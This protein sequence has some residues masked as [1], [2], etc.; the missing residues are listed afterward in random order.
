MSGHRHDSMAGTQNQGNTLGSRSCVRQS[1]LYRQYESGNNV[2]D[3]L[4][5]PNLRWNTSKKEGAYDGHA[6]Y[7]H[8]IDGYRVNKNQG[9]SRLEAPQPS[10]TRHAYEPSLGGVFGQEGSSNRGH[11]AS[12]SQASYGRSP[13]EGPSPS[14]TRSVPQPLVATQDVEND[15]YVSNLTDEEIRRAIEL[16]ATKRMQ[17]QEQIRKENEERE[18]KAAYEAA[19]EREQLRLQREMYEQEQIQQ[20]Q[21]PKGGSPIRYSVKYDEDGVEQSRKYTDAIPSPSRQHRSLL[22]ST[23]DNGQ[24]SSDAARQAEYH[25]AEYERLKQ[26]AA[27]A[28]CGPSRGGRMRN[29]HGGVTSLTGIGEVNIP[30][31]RGR[32]KPTTDV[33]ALSVV[34]SE[35]GGFGNSNQ[36]KR[37]STDIGSNGVS[38]VGKPWE[39]LAPNSHG[40][41]PVRTSR[42]GYTPNGATTRPW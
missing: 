37:S 2:K 23:G 16:E 15:Q 28:D 25:L 40:A 21:K 33:M 12:E 11:F 29:S 27:E 9:S 30:R 13:N 24:S 17:I 18:Y 35:S 39:K 42:N 34:G 1:K 6:I 3:I 32:A 14:R 7:D 36:W 38:A 26:M 22:Q 4:G 5:T 41:A 10:T 19:Y 8:N 31:A 20:Q